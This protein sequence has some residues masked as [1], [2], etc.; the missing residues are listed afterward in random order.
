MLL[1]TSP[2]KAKHL[3]II[4]R[5]LLKFGFV[6]LCHHF[7][8]PLSLCFPFSSVLCHVLPVS[9]LFSPVCYVPVFP[10]L[11][12]PS[13]LLSYRE[14]PDSLPFHSSLCR[15]KSPALLFFFLHQPLCESPYPGL[16]EWP[17]CS[18]ISE[19]SGERL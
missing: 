10:F 8:C 12:S 2:N 16:C 3:P 17:A 15:T 19:S 14:S 9:P 6:L 13:L 4:L 18:R 7:Y 1:T 11:S 5:W